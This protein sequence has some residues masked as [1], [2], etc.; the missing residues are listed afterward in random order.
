VIA[1]VVH[2]PAPGQQVEIS[3]PLGG[4]VRVGRAAALQ[5][6]AEG[7]PSGRLTINGDG[8]VP[9]RLPAT[10]GRIE[11]EVPLITQAIP[12][13]SLQWA[14]GDA[15]GTV[16][17]PFRQLATDDRLVAVAVSSDADD[18]AT[19]AGDLFPGKSPVLVNLDTTRT[20]L[21]WPP[22]A[23]DAADAILLDPTAAMRV[24]ETQLRVLLAAGTTVA[25]R[26]PTRPVGQW[27]WQQQ[28]AWWVIRHAPAGPHGGVSVDAYAPT[29]AWDRSWPLRQ[30]QTILLVAT[31][32]ALLLI[33]ATLWRGRA[34]FI[35]AI[36]FCVC[37]T[38]AAGF[39]V[40][41]LTPAVTA[42]GDIVVSDGALAQRDRWTYVSALRDAS[43]SVAADGRTRPVLGTRR[44]LESLKLSLLCYAAG[45]PERFD[46]A[47][48]ARHTV[49]FVS[50]SV[51]P[52][53]LPSE[54]AASSVPMDLVADR[55]YPGRAV[56]KTATAPEDAAGDWW[57]TIELER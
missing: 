13:D 29:Y 30:R 54:T 56:R 46:F 15:T 44:Q 38:A 28:G 6:S 42:G 20:R 19:L 21:L 32:A 37:A 24:D 5:V 33:G 4:Y 36:I 49:A 50:R 27:P 47:L 41:S 35:A 10:A 3:S 39:Y 8:A 22:Q 26:T 34:G 14:C 57:G 40:F 45:S 7:L 17:L 25:I 51:T 16:A 9:V 52:A 43:L 23:Y 18:A 1:V 12:V 55:L 53:T 48:P 11:A 2:R 31:L